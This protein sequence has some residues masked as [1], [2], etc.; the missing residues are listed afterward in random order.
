MQSRRV[1]K[2]GQPIKQTSWLERGEKGPK[3]GQSQ[4]KQQPT[5]TGVHFC[6]VY[7]YRLRTGTMEV[8]RSEAHTVVINCAEANWF[9]MGKLEVVGVW[10]YRRRRVVGEHAFS[11]D[12]CGFLMDCFINS[13]GRVLDGNELQ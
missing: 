13:R 4:S 9:L 3:E 10:Y 1:T 8:A 12:Q 11:K 5:K 2:E 7:K 6:T